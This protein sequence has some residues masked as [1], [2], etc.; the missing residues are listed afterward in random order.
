MI[1]RERPEGGDDALRGALYE[2]S[3]FLLGATDASARLARYAYDLLVSELGEGDPRARAV[4]VGSDAIFE[5]VGAVRRALYGSPEVHE[6]VRETVR[7]QGID[8]DEVALDAPRLRAILP[9]ASRIEAARAVYHVHRD[10]WYGHP[11]SLITWW[12]PFDDLTADETFV[13][14]PDAFARPVANDSAG[15]DYEAW[16]SQGQGLR[17]GWQD[18]EAGRREHY[19]AAPDPVSSEAAL[20]FECARG[21]NLLFAGAHLHRTLPQ[22]GHRARFSIDF[23]LVHLGDHEAGRGAPNV[24]GAAKGSALRDYVFPRR[25]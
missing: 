16:T 14:Y 12:I 15:F 1:R 2:G 5:V 11:P 9:G 10:T 21:E 3:I 6:L 17:I 13:F 18:R 23:R 19:P 22:E 8:P 20:G 24:D 7:A 4:R 25:E